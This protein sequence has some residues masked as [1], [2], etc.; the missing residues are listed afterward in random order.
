VA[1]AFKNPMAS[2]RGSEHKVFSSPSEPQEEG[3]YDQ[4]PQK[5]ER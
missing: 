3:E 5:V 2:R 4:K 1:S